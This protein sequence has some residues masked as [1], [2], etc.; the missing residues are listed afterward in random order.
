MKTF[1]EPEGGQELH[2]VE[3][4]LVLD[5]DQLG[6]YEQA[7]KALRERQA[8][9]A[10]VPA[11]FGGAQLNSSLLRGS[12]LIG[13]LRN[14]RIVRWAP[15]TDLTYCVRKPTFPSDDWYAVV[16]AN[17]LSAA[18]AWEATCG[19]RFTHVSEAD[20]SNEAHPPGVVF[21][22]RHIE[23]D[24]AFIAAAFFPNEPPR[25]RRLFI[26]PSYHD[27]PYDPVGVLRHE[28]GHILGFRHEQI[29]SGAPAACPDEPGTETIELAV[30]D[31]RSVMH[32]FCGGVGSPDLE[33]SEVDRTGSQLVY[34]PP[35]DR[36]SFVDV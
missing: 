28:L 23:A 30:Y 6:L 14:E 17:M 12:A 3:G 36:F 21:P 5:A 18:E 10:S 19:V 29:H 24:G 8:A 9:G 34:G 33:I 7:Q 20:E 35:L 26:D 15:G 31:P 13:I 32:Y 1:I 4:D 22:V 27:S 2:C 16:V 11:G 25:R